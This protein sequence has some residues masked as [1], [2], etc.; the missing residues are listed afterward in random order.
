VSERP[1]DGND[2]LDWL[3]TYE[4]TARD[5]LVLRKEGCC[6]CRVITAEETEMQEERGHRPQMFQAQ[7]SEERKGDTA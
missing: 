7:P 4:E 3:K 5:E 6:G 1:V 2:K